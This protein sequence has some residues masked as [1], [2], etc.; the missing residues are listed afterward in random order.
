MTTFDP[1]KRLIAYHAAISA[2]DFATIE[3]MFA[4]DAVYVS[5]GVGG[6]IEGRAAIMAAFRAYFD[7][8]GDQV[9]TDSHVEARGDLAALAVW[10]LTATDG[11]T[12]Q[13]VTRQGEET[14]FFSPDGLILRVD[15][16]ESD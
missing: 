9:S 8:F 16:V 11:R 4:E 6:R 5:G 3:A 14:I 1:V 13:R 10:R 12:G 2:L 15:V 7:V